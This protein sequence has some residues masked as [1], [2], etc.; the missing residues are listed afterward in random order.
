MV[1]VMGRDIHTMKRWGYEWKGKGEAKQIET[2]S[3]DATMQQEEQNM[4]PALWGLDLEALKKSSGPAK[5]G[6]GV[7]LGR[8]L[9][10]HTPQ[11]ARAYLL[12]SFDTVPNQNSNASPKK[13]APSATARQEEK[14]QNLGKLLGALDLLYQSWVTT[15]DPT[16][17]D[18]RAWNWYV[19]V[20]PEVADGVAG[21]G[22]KGSVRLVDILNL[23]RIP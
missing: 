10:I 7:G 8:D 2:Q 13:K 4:K 23:R 22:G 3:S 15:L 18:R 5:P 12:K 1:R 19:Q 17:L 6:T 9:P 16:E 11:S 14:Q 21:W 20:R